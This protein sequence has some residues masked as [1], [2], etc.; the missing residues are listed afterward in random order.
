MGESLFHDLQKDKSHCTLMLISFYQ[1]QINQLGASAMENASWITELNFY[2][3]DL[4][5]QQI[6][7]HFQN[8]SF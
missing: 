7:L 3:V 6:R 5:T 8:L 1:G 4:N 2:A